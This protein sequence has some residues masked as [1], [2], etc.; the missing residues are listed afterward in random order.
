MQRADFDLALWELRKVI[1]AY[2]AMVKANLRSAP[3]AHELSVAIGT[4]KALLEKHGRLHLTGIGVENTLRKIGVGPDFNQE[5][6]LHAD[7][8][9]ERH[10]AAAPAPKSE[11]GETNIHE[12]AGQRVRGSADPMHGSAHILSL[13]A[14]GNP[15][16]DTPLT[17]ALVQ[18]AMDMDGATL[19]VRYDTLARHARSLERRLLALRGERKGMVLVPREPTEEM[20]DA[21][22][23]A[24]IHTPA[25]P[26]L[27]NLLTNMFQA[28][29]SARPR[30]ERKE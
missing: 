30:D 13:D 27:E 8:I 29:L 26:N 6:N 19:L 16:T 18:P 28:M 14:T 2:T 15:I 20:I 1:L 4:A 3:R 12:A 21:A 22:L 5:V 7:T 10:D 24:W 11:A 9:A 17:D 23:S 25:S